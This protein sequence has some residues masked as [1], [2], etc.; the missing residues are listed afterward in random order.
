[1]V[2]LQMV[3]TCEENRQAEECPILWAFGNDKKEIDHG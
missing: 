2:D 3:E 1:M